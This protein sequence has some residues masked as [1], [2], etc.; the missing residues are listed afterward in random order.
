[1]PY[2]QQQRGG[3]FLFISF[4]DLD[5]YYGHGV[6]IWCGPNGTMTENTPLTV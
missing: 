2:L 4:N 6:G 3:S 1:M 5:T